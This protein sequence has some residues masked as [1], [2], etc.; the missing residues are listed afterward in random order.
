[1]NKE[2]VSAHQTMRNQQ[3]LDSLNREIVGQRKTLPKL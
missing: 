3:L 1:M 2:H